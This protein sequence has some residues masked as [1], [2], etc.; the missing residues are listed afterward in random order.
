[1]PSPD[2]STLSEAPREPAAAVA[3][4]LALLRLLRPKEWVKNGLVVAPAIFGE[5]IFEPD[6]LLRVGCAVLAFVLASAAGYVVNDLRDLEADRAHPV[7]RRRP[8]AAGA[9]TPR[10]A[11]IAGALALLGAFALGSRLGLGFAG[12]L[13]AYLV[14]QLGYS[15]WLKH[16]V[17]VDV[18]VIGAFFILR[19]EGGALAAEVPASEWLLIATG[20]LAVFLA[21]CK[22]RHELL[23]IG[24]D[25]GLHRAV[26]GQYDVRFLDAAISL[27]T[28]TALVTYLLYAMDAETVAKFGS[29]GMLAGAPFVLYGLLRYLHLAYSEGRGGQPAELAVTDPGVVAAVAGF[30]LVGGLVVYL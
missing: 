22:R 14:L 28:S 4:P 19:V 18:L 7:K 25:A 24:D 5:R 15:V 3:D 9:V 16:V 1:M 8:L 10:A 12:V 17:I 29:R 6:A 20:V 21:L 23:L 11:R 30:L 27:T 26:L 13:A 2:P